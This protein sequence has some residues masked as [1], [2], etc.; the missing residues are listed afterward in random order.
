MANPWLK[1]NPFVS[2]W[3]STVNRAA[4]TAQTK[5]TRLQTIATDVNLFMRDPHALKPIRLNPESH[6]TRR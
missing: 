3:L 1:K 2:M 5:P 4:D 6:T